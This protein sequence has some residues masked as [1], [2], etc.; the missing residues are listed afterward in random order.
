MQVGLAASLVACGQPQFSDADAH[1]VQ[2]VLDTQRDAWNAGDLDAFMAGYHDDPKIVFTSRGEIR[3]GWQ[4]ARDS[5]QRRYVDGD[6]AM[7]VLDFTDVE[8]TGL[9]PD[10]A[11]AMG[12]FVLT[13]TPQAGRGVF[14]LVF[15]RREGNWKILH[16]HSS[17]QAEPQTQ[18]DRPPSEAGRSSAGD[19]KAAPTP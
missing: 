9:G 4:Q 18:N 7:G 11:L 1:A 3:R 14:S 5:Y 13:E 8:I 19:D 10:A 6:A 2:A 17:G 12:H 15:T 16:D